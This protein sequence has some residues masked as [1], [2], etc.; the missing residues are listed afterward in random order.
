MFVLATAQAMC[1]A[2]GDLALNAFGLVSPNQEGSRAKTPV[3]IHAPRDQ[4]RRGR[5]S[6]SCKA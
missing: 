2:A 3:Q 4:R 5:P 6:F 1:E